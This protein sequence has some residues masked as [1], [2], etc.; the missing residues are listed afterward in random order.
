MHRVPP[1]DKGLFGPNVTIAEVEKIY[2]RQTK[3]ALEHLP[4]Y[5]ELKQLKEHMSS[6]GIFSTN[7]I[8]RPNIYYM[9]PSANRLKLTGSPRLV[10]Q[11]EVVVVAE[12]S[13]GRRGL[14]V[15]GHIC[16]NPRSANAEN[17]RVGGGKAAVYQRQRFTV[18]CSL[19]ARFT[20]W[21]INSKLFLDRVRNPNFRDLGASRSK[22][23]R[24][25]SES[26]SDAK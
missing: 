20:Q 3:V 24:Q 6:T 5:K 22:E 10:P 16:N 15:F 18:T 17:Y 21:E 2:T 4:K 19:N 1:D 23:R 12:S 26:D 13:Q 25:S 11:C 8:D 14:A 9:W 7:I